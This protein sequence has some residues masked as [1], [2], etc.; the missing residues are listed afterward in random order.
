MKIDPVAKRQQE[1]DDLAKKLTEK[2]KKR[3]IEVCGNRYD[4]DTAVVEYAFV[5]GYMES[6][7][8]ILASQSPASLKKLK[9]IVN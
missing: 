1:A 9:E 3:S 5:A 7:I 8:S 6:V 2:A 4:G